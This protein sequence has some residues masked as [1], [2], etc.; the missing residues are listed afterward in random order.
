MKRKMKQIVVRFSGVIA[1]IISW[2]LLYNS[3]GFCKN[4]IEILSINYQIDLT[5][6]R[7]IGIFSLNF[8]GLIF[9]WSIGLCLIIIGL[10]L[11]FIRIRDI[12]DI[13]DMYK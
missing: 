12:E 3:L 5:V 8:C 13:C 11:L 4:L 10:Y 6:L 2:K 7:L 9:T 1:T